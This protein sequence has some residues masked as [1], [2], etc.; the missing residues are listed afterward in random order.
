MLAKLSLIA[1]AATA[2]AATASVAVAQ[3][4]PPGSYRSQCRDVNVNGQFL[5]GQCRS[6]SGRY[7]ASSINILS[8]GGR[9][10]GVDA[11]GGLTCYAGPG[12]PPPV[13][14]PPVRPPHGGDGGGW[15]G[16]GGWQGGGEI[17]VFTGRDFRGRS[18][19][20]Q[21]DID[22]LDRSGFNDRIRSIQ[23]GRR[24]G[25]WEVCANAGFRG[26]CRIVGSDLRDTR[27]IGLD[28]AIS[29]IRRVR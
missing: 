18:Q 24:G 28:K 17:T 19:V 12:A 26:T 10:I 4:L 8:C 14:R 20:F 27:T 13:V 2:A 6:A 25:R 22:N 3:P 11:Q 29:S 7:A 5:A 23:V 21:G 16:G 1:L 15:H 9:D